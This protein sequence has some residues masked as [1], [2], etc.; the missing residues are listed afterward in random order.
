MWIDL[1]GNFPNIFSDANAW[2]ML[3]LGVQFRMIRIYRLTG[4]LVTPVPAN[5]LLPQSIL[6][7]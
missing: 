2:H 3:R 1:I 4:G 6:N 5:Q 7:P